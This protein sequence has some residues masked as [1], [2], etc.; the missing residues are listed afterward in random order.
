MKMSEFTLYP[1]HLEDRLIET[2]EDS[3]VVLVHGPRQCGKTT[4]TQMVGA[5]GHLPSSGGTPREKRRVGEGAPGGYEYVSLDDPGAREFAKDDP[6]GF[7]ASLPERVILDEVQHTPEIFSAIKMEVDRNRVPGRFMM[8]GSANVLL[9]PALSDSLAGRMQIVDL[10]PLAQCELE[11]QPS[12]FLDMLF[13]GTFRVRRT[14]R[15]GADLAERIVSG[16][17]PAALALP[18]GRRRYRWY[19]SHVNIQIKRDINSLAR[20][21]MLDSLPKLLTMAAER[22]ANLFNASDLSSPFQLSRTTIRDYLGLLEM[23]FLLER[24][25][26]WYSNRQSRLIKTPKLHI[27]DTGIACA[28][29]GV[30]AAGLLENRPLMGQLLETFVFHELRRQASWHD[31]FLSFYHYREKNGPEVDIVIER[32]TMAVAG[33]EVKASGTVTKSDFRGLRKLKKAAGSRF[34]AGVVL[35]D[36]DVSL[37]LGEGFYAV[38]LRMLWETP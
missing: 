25:P 31:D 17:Y 33:I 12:G 19:R 22:T 27:S 24:L 14:E 23:I 11:R 18:L 10:Y 16:G 28:L 13:K 15:L 35:Y 20:I 32:G 1:R 34:V 2:L 6:M 8:T 37:G 26:P 5:P 4:L 7:V 3:P 38:P 36:G 9:I 21:S 30:D 29:M